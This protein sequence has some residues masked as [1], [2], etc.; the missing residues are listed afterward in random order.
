[1]K[2]T[3]LEVVGERQV[4]QSQRLTV[5]RARGGTDLK[6][7]AEHPPPETADCQTEALGRPTL[8]AENRSERTSVVRR[9]RCWTARVQD[10][11]KHLWKVL[12]RGT[13]GVKPK[14]FLGTAFASLAF[15]FLSSFG[16]PASPLDTH[17]FPTMV[18]QCCLKVGVLQ[19]SFK[20]FCFLKASEFYFV[21]GTVF[22]TLC[23]WLSL[24]FQF[25]FQGQLLI[26]VGELSLARLGRHLSS[27]CPMQTHSGEW[28]FFP[29]SIPFGVHLFWWRQ[30]GTWAW[31]A[32]SYS[33][34]ITC[35]K[36]WLSLRYI[37]TAL[38][39]SEDHS[40]NESIWVTGRFL[41][42]LR[43]ARELPFCL[44]MFPL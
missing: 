7:T 22:L 3:N 29:A 14:A 41:M 30:P 24:L 13:G 23:G 36:Y 1:M 43:Q 31:I 44:W 39:T 10:N 8:L 19:F 34:G 12:S 15:L 38:R 33:H 40:L 9:I 32:S 42:L 27:A 21:F 18:K 4:P 11:L 6:L 17:L 16:F 37:L 25:R 26:K 20:F 2:T 5:S 28:S 35:V